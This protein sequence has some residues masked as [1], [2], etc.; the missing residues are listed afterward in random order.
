MPELKK[1]HTRSNVLTQVIAEY[2]LV[3]IHTYPRHEA[4]GTLW[5]AMYPFRYMAI[6]CPLAGLA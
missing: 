6:L 3:C 1:K 2:S 4:V 5:I